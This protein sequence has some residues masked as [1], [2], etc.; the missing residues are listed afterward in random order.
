[1]KLFVKSILLILNLILLLACR[2]STQSKTKQSDTFEIFTSTHHTSILYNREASPLDSITSHLLAEDIFKVTNYKPEVITNID[3]AKGHVIIIGALE[4][5]LMNQF[6]SP[7]DYPLEFKNQWESYLYKTVSNPNKN[8]NKAFV[9]AG[10]QPRGTAYGVFN[11]SKQIGVN[12]WYWWADVPAKK[13]SELIIKESNYF[14]KEPSVKF[15]GIFLNDEDWGLQPWAAK[16]FEPETGDIGPKT[17]TKIFELL[18]RLNANAIWPAMH[19]STKAFFHYPGNAKMAE[20]YNIVIGTSHAE[21]ML[22]NNV[23]EWD[24]AELGGFDYKNNKNTVY[25]YWEDR[26]KAAKNIDAIYTIGMRGVHDSGMEGVKSKDEAVDLLDG[27]IK[28]QRGLLEKYINSDASQV[29][30]AF[31]VYKEVLDLYKNGLEVPDDIT[32]V[33]TDDNYGYIRSLSDT[34]E[35]QRTGGGGVYYHASYWGRPHDYLWLSTTSPY[36]IWEEMMKAYVLNNK[37]IWILN[38]GDIKPA[39]YNTQLFLDMAYDTSQ[40]EHIEAIPQHQEDFFT[41]IFGEDKGKTIA[42]L[43]TKYYHLAFERKPEFMGW[44]QTEPTTQI[45]KSDYTAFSFGDETSIRIA[46]YEAIEIKVKSIEQQL[47]EELKSS[48]VQLVSYP[49]EAASNMNKKFLYRDKSMA[50]T[51]QG[52]TS[53]YAYR[54]SSNQ[55]YKKIASLT[56]K[57]NALSNGKWN[58]MM[59]MKP[60]NLPVYQMPEI[61]LYK[62]SSE[63]ILGVSVEDT[64]KTPKG[65]SKLPTFYLNNSSFHFIDVYLKTKEYTK[66]TIT[67]IPEWLNISKSSGFLNFEN[68]LEDRIF[69]SIDWDSWKQ[70]GKPLS[71]VITIEAENFKKDIQIN[72]SESYSNLTKNSIIETNGFAIWYAS[73]FNKNEEKNKAFWKPLKG[74]GHSQHAL[75]ASPLTSK[76]FSDYNNAPILEYQINTETITNEAILTLSALPTHP[77]TTNGSVKLAVQWNDE[78]VNIID[79]KTEGRSHTWKQNVLSNTSKKQIQVSLKNKGQQ[80]LKIY[81]IDA[82]VTLDYFILNTSKNKINPYHLG[83]ETKL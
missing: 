67:N 57:Y 61:V 35:Q 50:Y 23:D 30:Q 60:R 66:W 43:K 12:P 15:R 5:E 77:L 45:H 51:Y 36:L 42:D 80:T 21:P 27:I 79:F 11:L 3:D 68:S 74:L 44:S 59:D 28:D 56:E 71:E 47:P 62:N 4:S 8:I 9:I 7:Y 83:T 13:Q 33:W 1:M 24:K 32:L 37:N 34:K 39:E 70:S 72:I 75:Q 64:L 22:R 76:S 29:P 48:F 78:P 38:V 65:I 81:M 10:T 52:R 17:Y 14:S 6:L 82:G 54:D 41:D 26:V 18:L 40:F 46:T 16:T 58:G 20:L 53:A 19:P 31:T 73:S 2:A 69:I 63:D 25:N 55:A 49:V